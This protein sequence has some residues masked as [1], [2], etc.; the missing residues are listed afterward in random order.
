V[1][2]LVIDA[3]VAVKWHFVEDHSD[4][5]R[6]LLLSDHTLHAPDL[7]LIEGT[8]A[9]WKRVQRLEI[10]VSEAAVIASAL[11]A[12]AI[13]IH[14]STPLIAQALDLAI[15]TGRT[16]YDSLYLALAIGHGWPLVTA[17]QRFYNALQGTAVAAAVVW[18][19]DAA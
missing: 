18:V 17:D 16:I 9:I 15:E 6:A 4:Q 10:D 13:E 8:S 19:G 7:L 12:A 5:A 2:D 3:S 14:S 1:S 11:R